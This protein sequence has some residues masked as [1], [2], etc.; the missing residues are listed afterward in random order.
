MAGRE[1]RKTLS[2]RNT[3]TEDCKPGLSLETIKDN[4]QSTRG[5]DDVFARTISQ[6]TNIGKL[7]DLGHDT[8]VFD[9]GGF[10]SY[11]SFDDG[12]LF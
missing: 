6:D 9:D 3:M 7:V 10:G 4:Y 11:D 8:Q 1:K 5:Q 12:S 2:R